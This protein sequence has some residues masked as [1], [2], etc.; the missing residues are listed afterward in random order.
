[1]TH[2]VS[3]TVI[4]GASGIA[5]ACARRLVGQGR[6]IAVISREGPEGPA[7]VRE[8]GLPDAAFVPADLQVE[9]EAE[10]AFAAAEHLLGRIGGVV[11]VAGGSARGLGDGWLHEMS[12]AAWEGALGLNLTTMF[13]TARE[14]VRR[15][16]AHGGSLVLTS[17][18]LATSPQSD[19]F[20]THGYAAA[21]AAISGWVVPLAAA[22]APDGVRVNAVAPGL[23]RTPMAA[24][25]TAAP[26]IVAFAA[27]K[28]PLV[29]GLLT[30]D[31]VA[32]VMCSV[33]DA[34]AVTGQV[35]AVDGGWSVT[36]TS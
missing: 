31:D 14:A 25:A 34:P 5:A 24:R 35:V 7:L 3:G 15:M 18:V 29:A 28:Q 19:N 17:S 4:T 33:L 8:L 9:A 27:R 23:V 32:A 13:L 1:M 6:R 20:A 30:A 16:R 12:L 21:K 10:A 2:A 26:Q 36:S 11:A 22:Y